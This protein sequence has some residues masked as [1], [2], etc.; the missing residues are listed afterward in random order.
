M[1]GRAALALMVLA[2]VSA[3][4]A[5]VAGAVG[6]F[7]VIDR[8]AGAVP[9]SYTGEVATLVEY[10]VRPARDDAGRA[11]AIFTW[12]AHNIQYDVSF[13]NRQPDAEETLASRRGVCGG[14]AALFEAMVEMAGLEAEIIRGHSKGRGY[15]AGRGMGSM[16]D[17]AWNAVRIGGAW[18]LVDCTWGAGYI[19]EDGAF[20]RS[21]TEHYFLTSPDE[22]LF[23][24]FP[25]DPSWQLLSTP[26]T[27][28]EYLSRPL[29][30][31]PFFE[32]GLRLVSHRG[33]RIEAQGPVAVT[34][35]A[36]ADVVMVGAVLQGGK[37]LDERYAFTQR[38][39]NH[40]AV[41]A[42]FPSPGSYVLRVF[43]GRK[44]DLRKWCEWALDYAVE[45]PQ[46]SPTGGRFP[47]AFGAF[48]ERNCSLQGPLSGVLRA[49]ERVE[50][51]VR[52]PGAEKVM[53]VR[54]EEAWWPLDREADRFSGEVLVAK[55]EV[56]VFAKFP[57]KS[58]YEGLLRYVVE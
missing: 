23:D 5:A 46:G 26:I 58:R 49:G 4:G 11:R 16:E 21:F 3:G 17:H 57:G 15:A 56:M 18:E 27:A 7:A 54:S 6:R 47:K 48:F 55:G 30:K 36:P 50:F 8:Y 19:D 25:D 29:V 52:V 42:A 20:V 35:G 43:A 32:H 40:F 2:L 37:Q 53:V 12:I 9:A 22:F 10:L 39:G 51:S 13:L 45:V 41:R 14:Y 28:E 38:D 44:Q 1:S 24:H 33:A 34:V 31:A